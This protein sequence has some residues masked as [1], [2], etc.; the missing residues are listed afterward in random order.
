M[1]QPLRGWSIRFIHHGL[2]PTAI[3]GG[4]ALRYKAGFLSL[5]MIIVAR[6]LLRIALRYKTRFPVTSHLESNSPLPVPPKR[7]IK[8]RKDGERNDEQGTNIPRP[9]TKMIKDTGGR[10]FGAEETVITTR[11][12]VRQA[13]K[14][15]IN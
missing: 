14:H 2:K 9:G 3:H 12:I 8:Q 10:W 6:P 7:Q 13:C 1:G 5:V 4:I 11:K 15:R